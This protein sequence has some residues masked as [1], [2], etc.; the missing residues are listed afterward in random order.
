MCTPGESRSTPFDSR[1][2]VAKAMVQLGRLLGAVSAA[3]LLGCGSGDSQDTTA[4][5]GAGGSAASTAASQSSETG[6]GGSDAVTL[7][8]GVEKGPFIVG[9]S[10]LVSALDAAGTPT[11]QVFT[12]QTNDDT[13]TFDLGVPLL[14]GMSLEANGYYYN[15]LAGMLSGSSLTL[16]ALAQGATPGTQHAYINVLT[17]LASAREK[18]LVAGG[19]S[20]DAAI[21]QAEG[22]LRSALGIGPS[23]FSPGA[24]AGATTLLE[25][26]DD[27]SA[28]VLAVGAII[29]RAATTEAGPDGQVDA[30][31]QQMLNG[32][33]VDFAAAGELPSETTDLLH[34]AELTIDGGLVMD[35]LAARF[36]ELGVTSAV[37]NI[38]RVL[39]QDGDGVANLYD[40][41]RLVP[42]PDQA[43]TDMD[44]TGDA[45]VC[46]NGVV[47]EGEDCDDGNSVSGDDCEP[48]CHPTCRRIADLPFDETT[49]YTPI[50][51]GDKLLLFVVIPGTPKPWVVDVSTGAVS[52][53]TTA[54]HPLGGAPV[55]FDGYV[56]YL[57]D[58]GELWRT[59]GTDAGSEDTGVTVD[60]LGPTIV[61]PVV[62]DGAMYFG[63]TVPTLGEGLIRTDGTPA[64]TSVVSPMGAISSIYP[65]G[66]QLLVA[67]C[68]TSPTNPS[69]ALYTQ[70]WR[71]DG[72]TAGTTYV[73]QPN[74]S[75]CTSFFPNL[76]ALG[77]AFFAYDHQLIRTDGTT[78]G[79]SVLG[80]VLASSNFPLS[81]VTVAGQLLVNTY[82]FPGPLAITDGTP[83]GTDVF[84]SYFNAVLMDAQLP[85]AGLF[86][87]RSSP[88]DS[89]NLWTVNKMTGALSQIGTGLEGDSPGAFSV[90]VGSRVVFVEGADGV[91]DDLWITDGT[92]SGT[93]LYSNVHPRS[94]F[95]PSVSGDAFYFLGHDDVSG[96][97]PYRCV[98]P[99]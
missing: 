65:F 54:P 82:T 49:N 61:G 40:N 89:W 13:G 76:D 36:E 22:E 4:G 87:E 60:Y 32:M 85:D 19:M 97:D 52:Q 59:D 41:C 17:H 78:A 74:S 46:G 16:R 83:A 10:I 63:G 56:Y 53:L 72:T 92:T 38:Q 95:L 15:E 43:D 42:N 75:F 12:A 8:G 7:H 3:L 26:D 69:G 55:I 47:D 86:S 66:G 31:F 35:H 99:R 23:S 20:I 88:G 11:G 81:G 91:Y 70:L 73:A 34:D 90:A 77:Y 96:P 5:P 28:Y 18:T 6:A 24:A 58:G 93:H 67:S 57:S 48:D 30:T 80:N 27:A 1:G 33:T 79:T 29:L 44:G 62:F 45:C 21:T 14:D 50:L 84:G 71:S 98:I 2:K 9:T 25:G 68:G 94:L 64:G 37:P 51:L 39:D